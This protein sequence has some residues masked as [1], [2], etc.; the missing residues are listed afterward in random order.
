MK[1]FLLVCIAWLSCCAVQ[2]QGLGDSNQAVP[3]ISSVEPA[4][5]SEHVIRFETTM[6]NFTV[7]LYNDTPLHRDNFLKLVSEKF[8]DGILFHRVIADF[9]V[10]AGD[11][12]S[13]HA[14]PGQRLGYTAEPYTIPAEIRFPAHFHKTGA[15]AAAR[16]SEQINPE[17][18]SSCW[19][20]YVVTGRPC[21]DNMLE[22]VQEF[23]QR[24]NPNDSVVWTARQREI[25][26]YVGGA[27]HLD[28]TYT[29]FGEVVEGME[30]IEAIQRVEANAENRPLED[31]RILHATLLQ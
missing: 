5:S 15:L 22:Q 21:S 6:G 9:M 8:Y 11:S 16:E 1:I 17:L 3:E 28:G 19:Q 4:D 12:A 10:Q 18:A 29:V 24:R 2:A 26:N 14:E 27:P 31:V 20:F 25:Y 30:T 13:R 23:M 7:K